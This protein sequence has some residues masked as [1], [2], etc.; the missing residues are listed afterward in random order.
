MKSLQLVKEINILDTKLRVYIKDIRIAEV[1]KQ[2]G[3]KQPDIS[4]WINR[5]RN[6]SVEKILRISNKLG[7]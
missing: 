1:V 5:K 6:W 3:L 7:L 4:A 2:T